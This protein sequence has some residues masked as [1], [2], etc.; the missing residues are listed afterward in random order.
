MEIVIIAI[1]GVIS[2][3]TLFLVISEN[4]HAAADRIRQE[5]MLLDE[6]ARSRD[7]LSKSLRESANASLLAINK[8][9]ETQLQQLSGINRTVSELQ[10]SNRNAMDAMRKT[11]EEKLAALQKDNGEKLEKMRSVVDE[12]LQSALEKRLG[13]SFKIVSERLEQVY[14]GLGEMQ[15][16]AA[17]VGDLK[18]VLTNVK[19]RGTWGEVQ[20][21]AMLEEVL[22]PEQYVLN[23]S[24]KNN[25]DRVEFAVRMPGRDGGDPV[26]MPIDAKFPVEDYQR[27]LDALEQ[28][29]ADASSL[30]ARQLELRI[31]N[32]AKDIR[33]KY[34]NPPVTTDF[35][36]LYLPVEGLFAEVIRRPD[37]CESLQRECRV[38][39]AGPTTLWSLLSSLQMG[40]RTL[41]IEK[42]SSEVWKTLEAVKSEWLKYGEALEAVQ[43]KIQ[44][45]SDSIGS[46]QVR[47]RAIGR[48][49]RTVQELAE[50]EDGDKLLGFEE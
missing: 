33:D 47:V 15:T 34:L 43:K 30:A 13:E 32:A 31:R 41:A 38:V 18:R 22:A 12:K 23:F 46:A 17:G 50:P 45:A 49:L 14:K 27:L 37:L 42:R 2:A 24:S 10:E 48:K 36:I 16:L 3:V 11:V 7:E 20:L 28:G 40:F 35:A 21:G 8:I 26:Y 6:S 1:I 39:I 29:N 5:R 19:S 44:S 4:R 9:S 25:L